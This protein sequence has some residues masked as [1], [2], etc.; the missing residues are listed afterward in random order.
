MWRLEGSMSRR[1]ASCAGTAR[2]ASIN[3]IRTENVRIFWL[4][5]WGTVKRFTGLCN[6]CC[7]NVLFLLSVN[8]AWLHYKDAPVSTV[9]AHNHCL[10]YNTGSHCVGGT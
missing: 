7:I 2:N 6:R 10:L 5:A 9:C 3:K 8:T 1:S 4:W